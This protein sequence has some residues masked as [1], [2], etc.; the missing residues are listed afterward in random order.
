MNSISWALRF[1]QLQ[2]LY[3][4]REKCALEAV[5]A[6]RKELAR[7]QARLAEQQSLIMRLEIQL[8]QLYDRRSDIAIQDIST[9][10][11]RADNDRRSVLGDE[12]DTERF[13]L[14]G[15]ENDVSDAQLALA[16][17]HQRWMRIASQINRLE[18]R[19]ETLRVDRL[20]Q[21]IRREEG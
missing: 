10:S 1:N 2:R 12:L 18:Q 15:M 5:S 11:L 21:Q 17:T 3:G 4:L 13:Y 8:Q 16:A 14:P 7:V 19:M 20:R 6:Q 9:Q